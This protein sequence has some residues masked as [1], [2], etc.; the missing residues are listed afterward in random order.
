MT[1]APVPAGADA[2]VMLEHVEESGVSSAHT[3]RL[4]PPRT[5]RKGENVVAR[6]AQA[7]KGHRLL[8]AGALI[9]AAQIAL[10]ASCG[11]TTLEVFSKAA[12]G[13]PLYRR[14]TRAHRFHARA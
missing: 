4:L 11:S 9:G 2:V 14:R 3:I 7:R 10:A 6:G 12:R 13:Y 8:P 1:G 5:I